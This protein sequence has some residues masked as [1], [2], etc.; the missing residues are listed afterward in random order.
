MS[1]IARD[2]ESLQMHQQLG[3]DW[4]TKQKQ[5]NHSAI[6]FQTRHIYSKQSYSFFLKGNSAMAPTPAVRRPCDYA[7]HYNAIWTR[8]CT[9]RAARSCADTA[10]RGCFPCTVAITMAGAAELRP[11]AM[12]EK[13]I[14]GER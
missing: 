12:Q 9:Q 1:L 7:L 4:Y 14:E 10:H 3:D 2:A 8:L 6:L 11:Q 5:V 13:Y